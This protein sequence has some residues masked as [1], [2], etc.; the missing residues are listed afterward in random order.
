MNVK[1]YILGRPKIQIR[2]ATPIPGQRPRTRFPIVETS[3]STLNSNP[4]SRI[5][6]TGPGVPGFL[7]TPEWQQYR[8]SDIFN[9]SEEQEIFRG[10]SKGSSDPYHIPAAPSPDSGGVDSDNRE[11]SPD[12]ISSTRGL[13][14]ERPQLPVNT[15][16][17]LQVISNNLEV[18]IGKGLVANQLTKTTLEEANK[19]I[20][21]ALWV[22]KQ[23]NYPKKPIPATGRNFATFLDNQIAYLEARI[24]N[25]DNLLDPITET[26]VERLLS[27]TKAKQLHQKFLQDNRRI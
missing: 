3:S 17:A 12:S 18:I 13:F 26:D 21:H 27:C 2:P 9:Q 7:N 16:D 22:I 4:N 11:T 15:V 5:P 10:I 8:L 14:Y 20:R 1:E 19:C 6:L 24:F 23:V 25:P